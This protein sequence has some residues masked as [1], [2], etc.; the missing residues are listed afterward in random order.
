MISS[1][2]FA[3][4]SR[5]SYFAPGITRAILATACHGAAA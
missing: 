2:S 3:M 4:T 5:V 1:P